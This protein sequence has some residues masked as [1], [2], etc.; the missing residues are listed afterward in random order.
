MTEVRASELVLG[1][2]QAEDPVRNGA[3]GVGKAPAISLLGWC[4]SAGS[5]ESG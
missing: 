2:G 5:Q 3:I 1:V 4:C